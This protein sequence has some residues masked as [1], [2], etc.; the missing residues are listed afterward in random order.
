MKTE[1]AILVLLPVIFLLLPL[2]M[3]HAQNGVLQGSFKNCADIRDSSSVGVIPTPG[4][5]WAVA[6]SAFYSQGYTCVDASNPGVWLMTPTPGTTCPPTFSLNGCLFSNSNPFG[7]S[8]VNNSTIL[9]LGC[10]DYVISQS[11][12]SSTRP[13]VLNVCRATS[14][15][16]TP[17]TGALP[18]GSTI[19]LC[20]DSTG[21]TGCGPHTN[22]STG[23]FPS[24]EK[25]PSNSWPDGDPNA[26]DMVCVT[27]TG[28]L[29]TS[30]FCKI[31]SGTSGA[32]LNFNSASSSVTA[33]GGTPFT[34]AMVG[35]IVADCDA[36]NPSACDAIAHII[37]FTSS[38]NITIDGNWGGATTNATHW[39][40]FEPNVWP[41]FVNAGLGS[42]S[43]SGGGAFNHYLGPALWDLADIKN[44][45]GILS[46]Q[47]CQEACIYDG[48]AVD[49]NLDKQPN[50][51]SGQSVFACAS[52]DRSF[53]STTGGGHWA[54]GTPTP[55]RCT[56]DNVMSGTMNGWVVE[57]YSIFQG[58]SATGPEFWNGGTKEGR[59]SALF[60]HAESW[61]GI[62]QFSNCIEPAHSEY[63]N[64]NAVDIGQA[65]AVTGMQICGMEHSNTLNGV[66]VRI[67]T[68]TSDTIVDNVQALSSQTLI[69]NDNN[70]AQ[71]VV[72]TTYQHW[73]Q[74]GSSAQFGTATVVDVFKVPVGPGLTSGSDGAIAY[75]STNKNTHIRANGADAIAAAFAGASP[76]TNGTLS[77]SVVGSGNL[78]QAGIAG[79]TSNGT[80]ITEGAG[81]LKNGL[82]APTTTVTDFICN[83]NTTVGPYACSTNVGTTETYFSNRFT[84]PTAATADTVDGTHAGLL[85]RSIFDLETGTGTAPSVTFKL[86]ACTSLSGST[87]SGRVTIWVSG[88]F[89]MTASQARQ[90]VVN[91]E[92]EGTSTATTFIVGCAVGGGSLNSLATGSSPV[93]A[94]IPNTGSSWV[95][96]WSITYNLSSSNAAIAQNSLASEFVY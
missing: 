65:N 82:A 7:G 39:S 62:D 11:F 20:S 88:A 32:T 57:L 43:L 33:T 16:P 83:T 64:G 93:I 8:G 66:A 41:A 85:L 2:A 79:F 38:T 10:Y 95:M 67:H 92:V 55:P 53:R 54:F 9:N 51:E 26:P 91:C 78:L 15:S 6:A 21:T 73:E 49:G 68:G 40:I 70:T 42:G 31:G 56:T 86:N 75:D 5:D 28:G 87:C 14:S 1:K 63:V 45:V 29:W 94:G 30:H 90:A 36:T 46:P 37:A 77:Y 23:N 96:A 13:N 59:S 3:S 58:I 61:D 48:I 25:T 89:S 17:S 52:F 80:N 27:D 50:N 72:G 47:T 12:V 18:A 76:P 44:S 19:H 4:G 60:N 22:V 69:Q 35:G 24:F 74:S 84:V 81:S 34:A 71:N